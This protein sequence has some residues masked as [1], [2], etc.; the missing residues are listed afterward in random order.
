M[1]TILIIA[2]TENGP[3]LPHDTGEIFWGALAF[4]SVV[5]L[6]VWKA[7]PAVKDAWNTRID[8]LERELSAAAAARSDG[9]S[10]L[11]DVQG[12]IANAEHERQRILAEARQTAE[13]L[14]AQLVAKA[15]QD[16]ADLK[17]RATADVESAKTQVLGDLR[18]EV[19]QLALGAAEAVVAANLDDATHAELI[20]SY[21][22]KVGA[23]S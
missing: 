21:I 22:T 2:S 13:A 3:I 9:E 11:A 6:L 4:V 14:E 20:E 19:A 5:S 23:S 18:A 15:E 10:A 12:R 8:G 17:T 1:H 7:G 16:A